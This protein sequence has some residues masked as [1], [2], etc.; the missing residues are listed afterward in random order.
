MRLQMTKKVAVL[1]LGAAIIL[2]APAGADEWD[3]AGDPDSGI[4]TD[5][6]I[7]NG[8]EQVHDLGALPGGAADEDWYLASI[9]PFSSYQFVVDG[10]TGDLDLV[11][12]SVQRLDSAGTG[13]LQ[14]ASI[15]E[16]GGVLSLSWLKGTPA[17]SD[18]NFLRVRGA[19]CGTGC[20][21]SDRYRARLYDT[22]YTVPRF[23]NSGT[24]A[25]VLL[26]QSATDRFCFARFFFLDSPGNMVAET[27]A[28]IL[29]YA[30]TVL[31]TGTVA[32]NQ[33]GSIRIAHTCGYGGLSGKAVSV[34]PATGFTFDTAMVHRPR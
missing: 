20:T 1:A 3:D 13:V 33:S 17:P 29:P 27:S 4:S 28:S 11:S 18:T 23:N 15:L 10:L 2:G 34:E 32:P 31:P 19:N 8:A 6:V 5:N 22:T 12:G 26:V 30:L 24:Q 9:R 14:S 21:T 16:E 7:A 25:T